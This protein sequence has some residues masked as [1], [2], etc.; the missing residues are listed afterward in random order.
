VPTAQDKDVQAREAAL[1]AELEQRQGS[2]STSRRA[3]SPANA[4]CC[5]G[6]E[7]MTAMK[8]SFRRRVL[9]WW[10]WRRHARRMKRRG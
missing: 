10:I 4:A 2:A 8:R 1:R 5:S 3:R 7:P 6:S 9:D